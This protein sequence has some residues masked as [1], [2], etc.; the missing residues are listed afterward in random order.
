MEALAKKKDKDGNS[1]ETVF[2]ELP[3]IELGDSFEFNF[4]KTS[5]IKDEDKQK[6]LH[7]LNFKTSKKDAEKRYL[8]G[9]ICYSHFRDNKNSLQEFGNYRLFGKWERKSSFQGSEEVSKSIENL[10]IQKFRNEFRDNK[11]RIEEIL[12][13]KPSVVIHFNFNNKSWFELDGLIESIDKILSS[14]L[15]IQ[16]KKTGKLV[17]DKY[18]YKTL[19]GVTPGFG[20]ENKYKNKLFTTDEIVSLIYAT[21]VYQEPR[22][23]INNVGIIALPHSKKITSQ[24]IVQFFN[25]EKNTIKEEV[26]KEE[27]ISTET[28]DLFREFIQ[29]DFNDAVKFDI[30]FSSIPKSPAGVYS[31]LVEISNIE[32]SLLKQVHEKIKNVKVQLQEQAHKEFPNSKAP[33]NFSIKNSFLKILGD[34]TSDK[35]KYQFHL[36]KVLPQIYSDTYYQDPLLLPA[37]IGKVE[38]NI[39]NGGQSFST[40]KYDFYFLIN[41]QKNDNLMK[42]TSTKS[43]ALGQNLGIMARQFAAWRDDC[44]IK[45]FEKS[46]VGNLSRRITTLEELVKFAGF[47]NE[48]LTIHERLFP[49]VKKAYLELVELIRDFEGEKYSKH[50]CALGFFESYYGNFQKQE[51]K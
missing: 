29:N 10:F 11:S 21:Q 35:K 44:P 18:L 2:Y 8:L 7:Y 45:S 49:D 9:D 16:D 1:I 14:N 23:R 27:K 26:A 12:K 4:N 17:L 51:N 48:K 31:D 13:S 6:Q 38:H 42:I 20:D 50:N 32:K 34:L 3:V 46:Y 5:I 41:I 22:I 15:V 40:L 43:Y 19:G 30:I 24:E 39:R 47:I 33:Y 28:D 25:K 36:L 37:L